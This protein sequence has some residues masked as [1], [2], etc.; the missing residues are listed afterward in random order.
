MAVVIIF[1]TKGLED[2]GHSDMVTGGRTGWRIRHALGRELIN[3]AG[4]HNDINQLMDDT[5]ARRDGN[6]NNRGMLS[7]DSWIDLDWGVAALQGE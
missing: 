1:I 7:V 4:R 6:K 5:K 2:H 3:L